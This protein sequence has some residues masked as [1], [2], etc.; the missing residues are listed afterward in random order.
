MLIETSRSF[1]FKVTAISCFFF[2]CSV[3]F[4]KFIYLFLTKKGSKSIFY[5]FSGFLVVSAWLVRGNS[6][7]K[8]LWTISIVLS[9]F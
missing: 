7:R 2:F 4:V 6:K 3:S 8:A 1:F 5:A 9:E